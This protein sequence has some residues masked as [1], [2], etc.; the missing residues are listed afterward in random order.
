MDKTRLHTYFEI[1]DCVTSKKYFNNDHYSQRNIGSHL[2]QVTNGGV[3]LFWAP[4]PSINPQGNGGR[5]LATPPTNYIKSKSNTAF[6]GGV[7]VEVSYTEVCGSRKR[8]QSKLLQWCVM[9]RRK[10]VEPTTDGGC[11]LDHLIWLRL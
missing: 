2:Q 6:K 8:K 10:S 3:P 5:G 7:G 9:Y 11:L 4:F 1:G